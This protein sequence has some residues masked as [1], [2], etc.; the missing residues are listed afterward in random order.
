MYFTL[1]TCF[2]NKLSQILL[3]K[4]FQKPFQ[5]LETFPLDIFRQFKFLPVE[6]FLKK[7]CHAWVAVP[8]VFLDRLLICYQTASQTLMFLSLGFL[9]N[10]LIM[11]GFAHLRLHTLMLILDQSGMS[12]L[13]PT[14]SCTGSPGSLVCHKLIVTTLAHACLLAIVNVL[15]QSGNSERKS[16]SSGTLCRFRFGGFRF[17]CHSVQDLLSR[18][19][20]LMRWY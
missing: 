1:Y 6:V 20:T 7:I 11:T 8:L 13:F 19:M 10:K 15:R 14:S 12:E 2:K 9:G 16:T 3:F 18:V 5:N 4:P 17:R